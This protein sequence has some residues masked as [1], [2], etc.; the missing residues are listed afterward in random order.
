MSE[1]GERGGVESVVANGCVIRVGA[2]GFI[3][4]LDVVETERWQHCRCRGLLR[5][6]VLGG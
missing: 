4:A 3:V 5:L 6:S 2:R 1:P